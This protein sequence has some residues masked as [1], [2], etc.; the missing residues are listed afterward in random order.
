MSEEDA[1]KVNEL[2]DLGF[3]ILPLVEFHQLS[4][5][6]VFSVIGIT[7]LRFSCTPMRKTI[8][9]RWLFILGCLFGCRAI[10]III[11]LLPNPLHSCTS[12][13]TGSPWLEGLLILSTDFG[14]T[15][16]YVNIN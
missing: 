7:I 10:S 9:R 8:L 12:E 2:P 1:R 5:I 15:T 3:E 14:S 11:T 4:D 6:W 13:V 16:P